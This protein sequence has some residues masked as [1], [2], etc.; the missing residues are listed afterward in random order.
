MMEWSSLGSE[1]NGW[2]GRCAG[3]GVGVGVIVMV[4]LFVLSFSSLLVVNW[5]GID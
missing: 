1:I 2:D 3:V 5:N 4:L